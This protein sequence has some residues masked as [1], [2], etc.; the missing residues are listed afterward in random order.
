MHSENH[1]A[2]EY[3]NSPV[4]SLTESLRSYRLH[5]AASSSDSAVRRA[6]RPTGSPSR[7]PTIPGSP[8]CSAPLT[9]TRNAV[10]VPEAVEHTSA[11]TPVSFAQH[12]PEPYADMLRHLDLMSISNKVLFRAAIKLAMHKVSA[13][14]A[15]SSPHSSKL[16]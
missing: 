12:A 15:V 7:N 4:P 1:L 14:F 5:D 3:A 10:H 2:G 11:R 13:R 8:A 6:A 16:S 9:P